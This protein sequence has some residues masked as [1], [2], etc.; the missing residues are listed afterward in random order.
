MS[1][2][3]L[4]AGDRIRLVRMPDDPDPVPAGTEG[5]VID[6]TDLNFRDMRQVQLTVKWD[7]GRSLSCVCPPDIVERID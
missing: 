2:R 4:K 5:T 6:T 3:D 1:V 7:N